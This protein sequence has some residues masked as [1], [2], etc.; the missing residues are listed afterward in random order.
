MGRI[1]QHLTKEAKLAAKNKASHKYYWNNK[2]KCD[3]EAKERYYRNLQNNQ[4]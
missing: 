4:S 3:E 2:Q 1:K